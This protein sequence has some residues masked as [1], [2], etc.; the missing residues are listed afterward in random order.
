MSA[1]TGP[2]RRLPRGA[3]VAFLVVAVL[4][5]GLNQRPAIT[6][7]PPIQDVIASDL[8]M[9]PAV[10]GALTS[11]PLVCFSLVGL[12]VPALVRR[13]GV[14]RLML[15]GLI[16]L[17]VAVA[18][19]PWGGA[20]VLFAGTILVGAA[21][22]IANVLQP[23][24]I[25]RDVPTR[26]GTLMPVSTAALS[27]GAALASLVAVDLE[28]WLGWRATLALLAAPIAV[29]VLLWAVRVRAT[30]GEDADPAG[31]TTT[32]GSTPE[33]EATKT[34]GS[35]PDPEA[36]VRPSVETYPERRSAWAEGS[37]WWL[38][39]FF[40]LQSTLFFSAAAWLPSILADRAEASRSDGGIAL[41]VY[42]LLG[43]VGA[44]ATPVVV[45][46]LGSYRRASPVPGAGWAIGMVGLLVAPD[47]WLVWVIVA[48]AGQG[49][50]ISLGLTLV[51]VRPVDVV[52]GRSVSSMAQSVGYAIAAFGP[53]VLGRVY[54][55]TG[56]WVA[57]CLLMLGLSIALVVTGFPASSPRPLGL[58]R[59]A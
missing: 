19:R 52:H 16:L 46:L 31:T 14:D 11:V 41:T 59:G 35:T 5:I 25:R 49:M 44:L 17:G 23:V 58:P 51:A 39:A 43:V 32:T 21:I 33:P 20:V 53:V 7:I 10:T 50:G 55:L 37:S 45:R 56:D 22:T 2:S 6:A 38:A 3:S 30:S 29:A 24:V 9:G 8:G 57:G 54:G 34:T 48:G 40:G 42:F 4:V 1:P 13:L 27:T 47:A 18:A 15:V 28:Q 26:V 12:V 36:L